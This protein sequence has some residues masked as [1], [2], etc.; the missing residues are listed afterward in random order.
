MINA[1]KVTPSF[2]LNG[3]NRNDVYDRK[4][5][6]KMAHVYRL[7]VYGFIDGLTVQNEP[8]K[9]TKLPRFVG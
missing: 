8:E 4:V 7:E 5:A 3:D 6:R 9:G 2:H 1:V